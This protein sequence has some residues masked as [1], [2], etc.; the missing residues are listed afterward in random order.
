MRDDGPRALVYRP[1]SLG[2]TLV[3]LPAV[4]AIRRRLPA[5]RLT[6]LTESPVSGSDRVSPWTI[7]EQTGWFTDVH[8]YNVRPATVRGRLSNVAVAVRLRR[9]GYDE[10]FSLAPP[11]NAR[12]LRVDSSI[13]HRVVGASR[14]HAALHPVPAGG[15]RGADLGPVDH[16]GLRLLRIV[17]PLA[18][19]VPLVDFQLAVPADEQAGSDL[20]LERLGVRADQVLVGIGP[21]S[22]RSATA[23][24]EERFAAVGQALLRQ[25]RNVVLLAIGGSR[26]RSTCDQLCAAWGAALT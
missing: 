4:A 3:A 2:D 26:D 15:P 7:L 16:E 21:G 23:W 11:R 20:L 13:L 24:P 10:V 5:H 25:F 6:L 17:E 22:G 19:D 1:G 9:A 8:F 12:Q 14:Y 18:G